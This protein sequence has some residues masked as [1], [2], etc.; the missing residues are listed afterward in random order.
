MMSSYDHAANGLAYHV[1]DVSAGTSDIVIDIASTAE[2][3]SLTGI[4]FD[5]LPAIP[6]PSST[7]LL[8]ISMAGIALRRR[9]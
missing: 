7:L 8:G 1:F 2:N 3:R 4:G 5:A 9:R 6:E